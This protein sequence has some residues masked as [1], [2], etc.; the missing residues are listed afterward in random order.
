MRQRERYPKLSLDIGPAITIPGNSGNAGDIRLLSVRVKAE[1]PASLPI[2][3]LPL[4]PPPNRT[5]EN[6]SALIRYIHPDTGQALLP[7]PVGGIWVREGHVG[8]P[9]TDY[10]RQIESTMA[11]GESLLLFVAV[12][13]AGETGCYGLEITILEG[14]L[15]PDMLIAEPEATLQVDLA[16]EGLAASARY[17]LQNPGVGLEDFALTAG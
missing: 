2:L 16:A 1:S 6:V 10:S 15:N 8:L 13:V 5:A 9:D 3:G 14:L 4:G 7:Q 12:K 11:A 17:R